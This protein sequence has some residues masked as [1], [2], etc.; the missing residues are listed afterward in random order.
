MHN[1]YSFEFITDFQ[2]HLHKNAFKRINN[3]LGVTSKAT[4]YAPEIGVLFHF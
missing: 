4:D 3:A 1:E 2:F